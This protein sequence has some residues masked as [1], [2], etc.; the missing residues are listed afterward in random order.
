M[1]GGQSVNKKI[2]HGANFHLVMNSNI[3]RKTFAVEGGSELAQ[4]ISKSVL[5]ARK[6]PLYVRWGWLEVIHYEHF[7]YG[8]TLHSHLYSQ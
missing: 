8:L 1:Y 7:P 3:K 4:A 6:G 5:T 2:S